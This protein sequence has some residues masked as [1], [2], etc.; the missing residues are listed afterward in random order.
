MRLRLP[1][2]ESKRSYILH[3]ILIYLVAAVFGITISLFATTISN[4]DKLAI[5]SYDMDYYLEYGCFNPNVTVNGAHNFIYDSNGTLQAS[6]P[7][8]ETSIL[9]ENKVHQI[10]AKVHANGSYYGICFTGSLKAPVGIL[11]AFP[12]DDGGFFLFFRDAPFFTK[13]VCTISLTIGLLTA[14]IAIY[15][16]LIMDIQRKNLAMQKNY[17]D[18]ITHELKS[19]ISSVKALTE[20]MY[21]GLIHSEEK[22][23][24][25]YKI[26]LS[27]MVGL[28]NTVS[29]MLELSKIQNNQIDCSKIRQSSYEVFGHIIEKYAALCDEKDIQ[30]SIYPR[31]YGAYPL[32][33]NPSMSA[34]ILD[35]LLDNAVKFSDPEKGMITIRFTDNHSELLISIQNN[36]SYIHGN[37]QKKVFGRFYKGD[38]SHN[39][40]GSGLGLSIALEIVKTLD[41][42]LTLI[43]STEKGTIFGFTVKKGKT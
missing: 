38:K 19:P 26:I 29:N 36:G 39:E 37:E 24:R 12:L 31:N 23:K 28:E 2:T 4:K 10:G 13:S 1:S 9:R 18:N 17:I 25:Y 21:D 34:R 32:Y 7:W 42:E 35:I 15:L 41:E 43:E 33:T 11:T 6:C 30:F 20:T 5:A 22:R 14:M 8:Q 16:Y 3:W 27:E 40:K